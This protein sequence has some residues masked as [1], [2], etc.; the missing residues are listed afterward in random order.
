MNG[1]EA[2][3][4]VLRREGVEQVFCFPSNQLIDAAAAAGI[5]PIVAREERTAINMADAFTRMHNGKKIGVVMVQGGPGI[6]HSFGSVAQAYSDSVPILILP[7]GGARSRLGVRNSFDAVDAFGPITKWSSRFMTAATVSDQMRRAFGKLRGGRPGP[8]LLEMPTDVGSEEFDGALFQYEKTDRPR[9]A[10]DPAQVAEAVRLVL[11]AARP[12]IY[13]GQGVLWAEATDEL[14]EFA[15]LLQAPVLTSY[16]GKSAFPEDHPLALGAGG[17]ALSRAIV[18]VLPKA[19]FIFG[20]A[21]SLLRSLGALGIPA[22]LPVVQHTS[23]PD[24]L[25]VEY[26]IKAGLVGDAKLVL[27]QLNEEIRRQ[28]PSSR[29][30]A[31]A[32]HQEIA[33]ARAAGRRDLDAKLHSDGSPIN[34]YRVIEELMNAVDPAETVITHDSGYPRDHLAPNY[35]ATVPRGYLG[36]GN[37]TPL[38][39]SI[40]LALG[41]KAAA[42]DKT[43]IAFLGDAAFGQ[44]GMNVET[45]VRNHLP[46]LFLLVNNSEMGAYEKMLPISVEKYN[47]K[48]LSGRY[49]DVAAALGAYSDRVEHADQLLPALTK[50]LEQVANGQAALLEVITQPD[51]TVFRI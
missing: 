24:D 49:A 14:V 25:G 1:G 37:S 4:E 47:L 43:V 17:A 9:S 34:P 16:T 45:A 31:T 32:L 35:V 22:G 40:G 18:E 50:A 15:E 20:V 27:A 6:E 41:A 29:P 3:A 36:W 38:G 51:P 8:V 28:L 21:T 13:A 42:P 23:D 11:G 10:A 7:G 19:D 44:A 39:S 2:V 48:R 30:T 33:D 5:R 12:V 26:P 46:V